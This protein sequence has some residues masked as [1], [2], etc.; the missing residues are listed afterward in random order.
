[1]N[2]VDDITA[3]VAAAQKFETGFLAK[4]PIPLDDEGNSAYATS[5]LWVRAWII[6][7]LIRASR[8]G[9]KLLAEQSAEVINDN[10]LV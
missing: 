8:H 7:E 1:M 4:C 5:K 6:S 10:D 9:H 3:S 2:I